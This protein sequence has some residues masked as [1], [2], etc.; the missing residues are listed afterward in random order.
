MTLLRICLQSV[1]LYGYTLLLIR[2]FTMNFEPHG[3]LYVQA[4]FVPYRVSPKHGHRGSANQRNGQRHLQGPSVQSAANARVVW[5]AHR[6]LLDIRPWPDLEWLGKWMKLINRPRMRKVEWTPGT[7]QHQWTCQG[8]SRS[9]HPKL[10][11]Q[12]PE[13]PNLCRSDCYSWCSSIVD[14][15]VFLMVTSLT[16]T[17]TWR[18]KKTLN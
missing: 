15:M 3:F 17:R 5:A 14:V 7:P 1:W 11:P 8:M 2:F 16:L 12:P 10:S 13:Q 9:Y 4:T 6:V 18:P